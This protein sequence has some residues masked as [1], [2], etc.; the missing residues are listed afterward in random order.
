M[1]MTEEDLDDVV[2][3]EQQAP[4]TEHRWIA[5]AKANSSKYYSQTWFYRNM[6]SA[7]NTTQVAKFKALDD[8]LYTV[9]FSCLGYWERVIQDGPWNF[10]GHA[11]VIIEYDG[12][13][14]PSKVKQL[15]RSTYGS[16]SMFRICMNLD[17]TD[18]KEDED[19]QG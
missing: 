12:I 16:R 2:F 3:D 6:R 4:P 8:N 9:K 17:R 11:V 1:G 19:E 7:W 13:T 18:L 14:Q 10:R 5:I 15:I